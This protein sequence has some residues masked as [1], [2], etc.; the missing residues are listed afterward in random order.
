MSHRKIRKSALCVTMSLVLALCGCSAAAP[1]ADQADTDQASTSQK[2]ADQASTD[3]E[4]T[5][6]ET[7]AQ[8]TVQED[9]FDFEEG[10]QNTPAADGEMPSKFD[11]R[12]VQVKGSGIVP[13]VRFQNPF[14]TCWSF[15]AIAAAEMSILGSGL[16]QDDGYT[17]ETFDLSEKHLAYFAYSA[18]D[19]PEDPQNGEGMKWSAPAPGSEKMQ[20]GET[21]YATWLFASGI[22][23]NLEDRSGLDAGDE[24]ILVYKGRNSE[25]ESRLVTW[26][27]ENGEK[28][29]GWR[30]LCYSKDDDWSIPE[31]Y[32]FYQS[33]RLK[34]SYILP[35]PVQ[36]KQ[37]PGE[38]ASGEEADSEITYNPMGTA[39]IKQ[40]LL[41]NRAVSI[42]LNAESS[43][44]DQTTKK[45]KYLS[46]NWAQYTYE[47]VYNNPHAVCIVGWDDDYPKEN[48][49]EGHQ[50]PENGAWLVRNSWGS[51][52]NEFPTNGYRHW[53]IEQE[54]NKHNGYY[55]V[56]YYDHTLEDPE[57][58]VFDKSNVDSSYYV[59]QYDYVPAKNIKE[60]ESAS[61]MKTANVFVAD[62][63]AKLTEISVVTTTPN[64]EVSYEIF[65]L[66][67]KYGNPSDGV[68][69]QS[70][71]GYTFE[72]GGYHRFALKEPVNLFRKQ[73][74][75]VVISQKT[76]SGKSVF[77]IVCGETSSDTKEIRDEL[78]V[79]APEGNTEA[80]AEEEAPEGIT[81]VA[82]PEVASEG[83]SEEASDEENPEETEVE[84]PEEEVRSSW[85]SFIVNRRESY[86]LVD[87]K[88]IDLTAKEA[89]DFILGSGKKYVGDLDTYDN[90]PIKAYLEDAEQAA[91]PDPAADITVGSMPGSG[92]KQVIF[93]LQGR[94]EEWDTNP[95][96]TWTSSDTG[97]FTVETVDPEEGVMQITG[98]SPGTA[99][100]MISSE[101][102]GTRVVGVKVE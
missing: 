5:A 37:K 24:E 73:A 53:G 94:V 38:E 18:L 51:D 50:P 76:P 9:V 58:F 47:G 95:E 11:L 66:R 63:N 81:E 14:G 71:E 43:R 72:Y 2:A 91:Y 70:G 33:Y 55:W 34:D 89:Y 39:A 102:L 99:Y 87:G 17:A 65:L 74:Y 3:Q 35:C 31:K 12:D 46:P 20:G 7:P 54:E 80:A 98:I 40:Q 27:D 59:Q 78:S 6:G 84:A 75:S 32:R 64:S 69:I 77:S 60:I 97:I 25:T 41:A 44:P 93:K 92:S 10:D 86:I 79:E 21:S 83:T 28:H 19:D 26:Y 42:G 22:G 15:G 45:W 36:Q 61:E 29:S 30:R 85:E 13:P 48:F 23:P 101:E 49:I 16:A 88:W 8:E 82:A 100:L 62:R 57:A 1:A 68:K 96:F 4:M 67:S 56:S 52:Y 90:L